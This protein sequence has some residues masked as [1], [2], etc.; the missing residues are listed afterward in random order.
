ME[1]RRD[2]IEKQI[3]NLGL[4]LNEILSNP[5]SLDGED[6]IDLFFSL[7]KGQ[8]GIDRVGIVFYF[9]AM[10]NL[11]LGNN[12]LCGGLQNIQTKMTKGLDM[13]KSGVQEMD[14][15]EMAEIDGGGFGPFGFG[16]RVFMKPAFIVWEAQQC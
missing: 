9:N 8:V 5:K 14:E 3:N 16:F 11:A 15:K 1:Q 4:F 12:H 6:G 2:Y 13:A 7:V 10:N